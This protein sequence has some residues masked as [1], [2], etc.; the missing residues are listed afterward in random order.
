MEDFES[1]LPKRKRGANASPLFTLAEVKDITQRALQLQEERL[2][3]DYS[4]TLRDKLNG[5]GSSARP[6]GDPPPCPAR[7][8]LTVLRA[9][10]PLAR[11][12]PRRARR[13]IRKFLQVQPRL[14]VAKAPRVAL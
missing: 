4:T 6:S 9:R 1:L 7:R 3:A 8:P 5:S 14:H 10:V 2:Q 11:R 13:A 12:V